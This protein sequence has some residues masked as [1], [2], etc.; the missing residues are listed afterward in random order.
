MEEYKRAEGRRAC[1][2]STYSSG[3]F[4]EG[5]NKAGERRKRPAGQEPNCSSCQ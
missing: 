2:R 3:R 4:M 1:M 5:K